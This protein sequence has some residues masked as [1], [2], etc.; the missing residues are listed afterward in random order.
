MA[1]TDT[2]QKQIY[3]KRAVISLPTGK[4][5]EDLLRSALLKKPKWAERREN[6]LLDDKAFCFIN[7][8]RKGNHFSAD[9]PLEFFVQIAPGLSPDTGCRF[10]FFFFVLKLQAILQDGSIGLEFMTDNPAEAEEMRQV[11]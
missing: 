5:L 9:P 4:T 8:K 6:P 1:S 10:S 3:Y 7:H 11:F 2:R